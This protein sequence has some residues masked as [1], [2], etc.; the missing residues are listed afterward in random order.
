MEFPTNGIFQGMVTDNSKFF[1]TGK[2][3]IRCSTLFNSPIQWD[4]SANFN[5]DEY[6][7]A[8]K[9]DLEALVY[10]PMG[11]GQNHG[12]LIIPQVNSVGLVMFMDG[13]LHKPVWMGAFFAPAYNADGTLRSVNI[14]NDQPQ[15]EGY[16]NDGIWLNSGEGKNIEGDES[17]IVLR[18]KYTTNV[19]SET[20][21]FSRQQTQNMLVLNSSKIQLRHFTEWSVEDG[22]A[23]Q[24]ERFMEMLLTTDDDGNQEATVSVNSK[25]EDDELPIRTQLKITQNLCTLE[26]I[27]TEN[28][29]TN[30]V[31]VGTEKI[32]IASIDG[33]NKFKT[34]FEQTPE[35]I[36]LRAGDGNDAPAIVLD[37]E[38][39]YIS[40]KNIRLNAA[41]KTVLSSAGQFVVTSPEAFS[42]RMESGRVL[43]T[44]ARVRV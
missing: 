36:L 34:L 14:P 6:R 9:S 7:E 1:D 5:E 11:G 18:Q 13:N 32:R 38:E 10:T 19:D 17:S 26:V 20:L 12:L 33:K 30:I 25:S 22:S 41:E 42:M 3:R 21:D 44:S 28:D 27:D 8:I 43:A 29:I 39:A 24:M 4:L 15:M 2:V 40:G 31:E 35:K 37:Q 16:G 23:P